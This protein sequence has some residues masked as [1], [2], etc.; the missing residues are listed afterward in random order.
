M[1]V[2]ME[3]PPVG[4]FHFISHLA[5][6]QAH[7]GAMTLLRDTCTAA[8]LVD[9]SMTEAKAGV[10]LDGSVSLTGIACLSL[11]AALATCQQT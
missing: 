2:E 6:V 10:G 4:S 5:Y 9:R 3:V 1:E 8:M 11:G 7:Q